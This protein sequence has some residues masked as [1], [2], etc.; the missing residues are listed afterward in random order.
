MDVYKDQYQ[1]FWL[2]AKAVGLII[3]LELK[4]KI[5]M[6]GADNFY[7]VSNSMLTEVYKISRQRKYYALKKLLEANL[8]K[9]R[10]RRGKNIQCKLVLK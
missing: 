2:V 5:G 8:I 9:V 6:E 10:K 3:Y 1:K 4:H 7:T